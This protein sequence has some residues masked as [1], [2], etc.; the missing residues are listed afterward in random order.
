MAERDYPVQ[1][2][3]GDLSVVIPVASGDEAWRTLLAD[4]ASIRGAEVIFTAS[5]DLGAEDRGTIE[6]ALDAGSWS[7]L[8]TPPGRARQL[9]AGGRAAS[10]RYLW[11]LHADSRFAANTLSA[12]QS[13]LRA[14]PNALLYFDLDFLPDGP[15]A[16]RLNA[17]GTC[18]RSRWFGMPF[19]D[20]GLCILRTAWDALG[21]FDEGAAYGED[22][23]FVWR[24]RRAGFALRATGATLL[25]SARRYSE[26]GWARTTVR[27][28]WLTARQAFPEWVALMRQ[29]VRA[30]PD[31]GV[32]TKR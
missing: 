23:L 15:R 7:W 17:L 25:T 16:M 1:R 32:V 11:F 30:A 13:A 2:E 12:L 10:R 27:H 28:V 9:N 4:L 19:G 29:R 24:A 3:F 5:R 14:A 22:H 26:G 8:V 6:G 18:V 20:Q 31:H 21:A